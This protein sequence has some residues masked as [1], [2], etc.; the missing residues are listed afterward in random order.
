MKIEIEQ[1]HMPT[2]NQLVRKGRSKKARKSEAPALQF[3]Y[4]ALTNR[5]QRMRGAPQKRGVC[6]QVRT[7]TPRKP[8]SRCARSRACA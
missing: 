7:M 6:T 2:I 4:N 3:S 5:T 1:P 8:N